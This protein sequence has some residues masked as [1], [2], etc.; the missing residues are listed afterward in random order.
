VKWISRFKSWF[1]MSRMAGRSAALP[2][3]AFIP[4]NNP[5]SQNF[6]RRKVDVARHLRGDIKG[7]PRLAQMLAL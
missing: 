4:L 1:G 2:C 6:T 3:S 7:R 5:G